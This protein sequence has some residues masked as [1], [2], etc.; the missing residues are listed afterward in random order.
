MD[1]RNLRSFR[2]TANNIEEERVEEIRKLREV[3]ED[4][5]SI[6]RERNEIIKEYLGKKK[7]EFMYY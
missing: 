3:L 2:R 1:M 6:Q 5:N 7:N 4:F